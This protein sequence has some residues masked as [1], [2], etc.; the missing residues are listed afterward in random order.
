MMLDFH[1]RAVFPETQ[2]KPLEV[3]YQH[4]SRRT[5]LRLRE[6]DLFERILTCAG[7]LPIRGHIDCDLPPVAIPL[8]RQEV[9]LQG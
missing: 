2:K 6:L 8:T 3:S 9:R 7:H 5:K 4:Q 1:E